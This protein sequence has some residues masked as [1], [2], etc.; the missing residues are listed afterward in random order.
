MSSL[1]PSYFDTLYDRN[2]DPW[3][4][5]T[6]SYE[7][8]KYAATIANLPRPRYRAALEIGCSIGVL[9]GLLADRCD[10]VL[11][12]DVAAAAV[13][14][15]RERN[16][17]RANLRFECLRFPTELPS[18]P[19]RGFDL[20]LLSEVLYYFDARELSDV[21]RAVRTVA[22]TAAQVMLVHWLGPTPDYPLTGD[23]AVA[24]FVNALQ[25]VARNVA[26]LRAPDYRIDLLQL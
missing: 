7:A 17:D 10:S 6:R 24:A 3:G 9:S 20:I 12:L 21:A 22:A 15:A 16:Q 18:I 23:A 11:A 2:S 26:A 8:E 19:V 13:E 14:Q 1:P 25:P 5:A 4:F